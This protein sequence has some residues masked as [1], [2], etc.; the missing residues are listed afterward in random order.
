MI[1]SLRN[2][3]PS[4]II[5]FACPQDLGC[6]HSPKNQLTGSFQ[7]SLICDHFSHLLKSFLWLTFCSW[8]LGSLVM[9]GSHYITCFLGV[10][11]NCLASHHQLSASKH[12]GYF[13]KFYYLFN[14]PSHLGVID[15]KG[16]VIPPHLISQNQKALKLK[17]QQVVI[18][19]PEWGSNGSLY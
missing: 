4:P 9:K 15:N 16:D 18:Q 7:K 10:G 11:D 5:G 13:Y 3:S 6:C 8:L 17:E 12:F 19:K 14:C 1:Y 2:H